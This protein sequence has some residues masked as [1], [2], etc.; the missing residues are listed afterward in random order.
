M[1]L[2]YNKNTSKNH[3][4]YIFILQLFVQ[5]ELNLTQNTHGMTSILHVFAYGLGR[6]RQTISC[7]LNCPSEKGSE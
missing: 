6:S 3:Y 7:F 5:N 2:L 4:N 1:L